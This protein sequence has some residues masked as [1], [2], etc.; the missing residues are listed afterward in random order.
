MSCAGGS[1]CHGPDEVARAEQLGGHVVLQ[2]D[3][4]RHDAVEQQEADVLGA[5]GA[6]ALGVPGP[7]V[8]G[9]HA[10]HQLA[11]RFD[12]TL[13]PEQLPELGI[14]VEEVDATLCRHGHD[15][16]YPSMRVP[17][18]VRPES[19]AALRTPAGSTLESRLGTL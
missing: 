2:H 16:T 13:A 9:V 14:G 19:D 15:K 17:K 5:R 8:R 11:A 6:Q 1:A 12:E 18:D 7:A 3:L 10:A 4:P